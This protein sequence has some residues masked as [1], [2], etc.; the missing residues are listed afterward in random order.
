VAERVLTQQELNRAL[1]ERQMLLERHKLGLPKALERMGTLQAQYAPSMYVGLWSRVEGFER[2]VLT[3][4]LERRSAVQG[5]L[6]RATIHLASKADYWPIAVAIREARREAF[7]KG[8][9]GR[10]DGR[11]MQALADRLRKRLSEKSPLSRKEIHELLGAD[12]SITNGVNMWLDLVRVPP[13]G[14]WE[15]RRADLYAAAE[16]W[17]GPERG[18]PRHGAE[19]LVRRYLGGFGPANPREIA[20]WAG[21]P[22]KSLASVIEKLTLRRFQSEDGKE[23]VDLPRAALPP[24]DAPAPAR[25]LPVWDATLLVHA[26][27]TGILPEEHRSKVFNPK[28]PQSVNTFIVDGAVAGAWKW[29][30][31][32]IRLS[33]FGKLAKAARAE[34]DEEA[35]RLALLYAKKREG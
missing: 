17:I 24:G 12:P 29:D 32:R 19:L 6:M 10:Y 13:S 26:R 35:E 16:D 22:P 20:D 21:L 28:T 23:L 2:D 15:R 14:T 3:T 9:R 31:G 33:P 30:R 11:Q 25:F 1:L 34:L 18:D 5:T 8:R 7:L 27:R 4:A